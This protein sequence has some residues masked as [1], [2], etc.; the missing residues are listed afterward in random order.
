MVSSSRSVKVMFRFSLNV[1][2][3][4]NDIDELC[5]YTKVVVAY[6]DTFLYFM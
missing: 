4:Q 3:V 6:F 1:T 2:L 5:K